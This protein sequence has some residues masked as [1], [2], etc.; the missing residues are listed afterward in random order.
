[1]GLLFLK[2][3]L[4]KALKLKQSETNK[5][6][7]DSDSDSHFMLDSPHSG[8]IPVKNLSSQLTHCKLT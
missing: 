6:F 7:A 1:M 5:A 4:Y 8:T 2:T 3:L